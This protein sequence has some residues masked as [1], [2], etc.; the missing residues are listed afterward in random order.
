MKNL[1]ANWITKKSTDRLYQI[2]VPII[3]LTGGIGTGKSSVANFL[4]EKKIAVID[5]DKLVKNI[6]QKEKT[7]TFI[8]QHFPMALKN[9]VIDFSVL[10]KIVFEQTTAKK[11][12]EDLIYADMPGEFKKAYEA[13]DHPEFV[14]Y[15]VPLL[16]EKGLDQFVDVSVCVYAPKRMQI[17]RIVKRDQSSIELATKIING[18]MDIEE[19][20]SRSN[21]IIENVQGLEELKMKT[22]ETLSNILE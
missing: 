4:R 9:E 6:Y 16:F 2:P 20:K 12:I 22:E 7:K 5:A 17:E 21:F 15:D 10:R 14:V 3:G 1:K 11:M 8:A 13:F 19:K 18:Q